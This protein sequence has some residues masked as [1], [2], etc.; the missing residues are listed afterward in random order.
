[1]DVICV[2]VLFG[3]DRDAHRH[4]MTLTRWAMMDMRCSE[5]CRLKRTM[6]PSRRCLSTVSPTCISTLGHVPCDEIPRTFVLVNSR[7][8]VLPQQRRTHGLLNSWTAFQWLLRWKQE[9][10]PELC[11]R[12]APVRILQ[13]LA[14][15]ICCGHKVGSR[16]HLY[17]CTAASRF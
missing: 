17:A 14:R 12:S 10:Y 11:C 5:G 7:R 6:S 1:M 2:T 3:I 13:D 4:G 15:A 9:P 8:M 16:P